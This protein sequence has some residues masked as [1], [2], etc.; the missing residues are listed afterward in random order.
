MLYMFV[1]AIRLKMSQTDP[2]HAPQQNATL[3]VSALR[4]SYVAARLEVRLTA[5]KHIRAQ[6]LC[7]AAQ[8]SMIIIH[9]PNVH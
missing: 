5:E 7:R 6:M 3:R 8:Q 4:Y 1:V 2:Y 9:D